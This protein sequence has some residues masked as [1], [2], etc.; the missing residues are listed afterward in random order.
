MSLASRIKGKNA[1]PY[2]LIYYSAKKQVIYCIVIQNPIVFLVF[3]SKPTLTLLNL[4]L[5]FRRSIIA[6]PSY[7]V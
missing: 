5:S 1:G 6:H 7:Y 2:S 3:H 4:S